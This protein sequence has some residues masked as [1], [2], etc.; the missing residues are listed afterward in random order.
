MHTGPPP[1]GVAGATTVTTPVVARTMHHNAFLTQRGAATETTAKVVNNTVNGS[2]LK[3]SSAR[4][5]ARLT[6]SLAPDAQSSNT[7]RADNT[8]MQDPNGFRKVIKGVEIIEPDSSSSEAQSPQRRPSHMAPTL[9]SD[10]K[11][12]NPNLSAKSVY[13]ARG[14][15]AAATKKLAGTFK[16]KQSVDTVGSQ[17]SFGLRKASNGSESQKSLKAVHRLYAMS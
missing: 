14:T 15:D 13:L 1:P 3:P 8:L 9:S 10:R 12:L 5:P 11:R 2:L 17:K 4:G 6:Q 7:F 16:R